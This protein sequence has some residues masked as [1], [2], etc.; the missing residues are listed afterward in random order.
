MNDKLTNAELIINQDGSIYHLALCPGELAERIILVGDPD[1]V[2]QVSRQFDRIELTRQ[3]RE[4]I[5]HTGY[6]KGQ[7]LS[8][9]STGI[10]TDN[11]DIVVNEIDALFNVDVGKRSIKSTLTPLVLVRVG[12]C[13]G[14][15]ADIATDDIVASSGGIGFDGLLHYYDVTYTEP[16]QRLADA[17]S[18]HCQQY[19]NQRLLPYACDADPEL[20]NLFANHCHVGLTATCAGFYGPQGR[21]I[22]LKPQMTDFLELIQQFCVNRGDSV[23]R[24]VNFEMETAA[25]YGLGNALSHRCLSLS[26]VV[27]NR[28]TGEFSRN[29][30][31]S[32]E[33]LITLTLD[34]LSQ[35]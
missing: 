14:L 33:R 12:T 9:I 26:T 17:I 10:G 32:M 2:A 6:Y 24:I 23:E 21:H 5:T 28:V 20:V 27:A 11:I 18:Q 34:Q 15:Q 30:A 8:V 29:T 35:H 25:L 3:K 19:A 16:E 7:R 22:R 13:G 4:F 31:T 1:R